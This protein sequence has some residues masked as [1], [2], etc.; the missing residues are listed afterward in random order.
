[1]IDDTTPRYGLSLP[2][3]TNNL[4][5]DVVRL[6]TTI[7]GVDGLIYSANTAR[8]QLAATVDAQTH[9][10]DSVA[11]TYDVNGRI[12]TITESYGATSYVI[13][14][15]YTDDLVTSVVTVGGGV[16]RTET[17]SYDGSQRLT[18]VV[19]TEVAL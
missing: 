15:S 7:G 11:M 6:R 8:A 2:H 14:L 10:A 19:A 17:L 5:E 1:M 3:P 16:Q 9:W 4:N 12:A 18:G 13:T